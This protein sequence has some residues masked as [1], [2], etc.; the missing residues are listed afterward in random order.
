MTPSL[1]KS[2]VYKDY[3]NGIYKLSLPPERF[4]EQATLI[5]LITPTT[6]ILY[7]A[8][9]EYPPL[10]FR[11]TLPKDKEKLVSMYKKEAENMDSVE[12]EKMFWD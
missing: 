12:I 4:L 1:L 7:D 2:E 6:K 8:I 10:R 5:G 11:G 9:F 3:E